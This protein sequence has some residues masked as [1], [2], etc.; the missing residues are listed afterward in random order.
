M[1]SRSSTNRSAPA[2]RI[3]AAWSRFTA[4]HA[5]RPTSA[6]AGTSSRHDAVLV[7]PPQPPR[8]PARPRAAGSSIVPA[9]SRASRAEDGRG[10]DNGWLSDPQP[11][12]GWEAD[13][14]GRRD[15]RARSWRS[16][17]SAG[18]EW[19]MSRRRSSAAADRTDQEGEAPHQ[20]TVTVGMVSPDR[21]ARGS[22]GTASGA[23]RSA[24]TASA[25]V[26]PKVSRR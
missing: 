21:A 10:S 5:A 26:C 8:R 14:V 12:A 7:A 23:T 16:S 6:S 19:P 24:V 2:A 9:D 22:T 1:H 20:C 13:H 18:R 11:Q 3:S 25:W 17:F 15:W 4:C